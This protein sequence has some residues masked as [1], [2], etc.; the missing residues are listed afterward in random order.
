MKKGM[1]EVQVETDDKNNIRIIQPWMHED[2]AVILITPEQ[3]DTLIQWLQEAK[4]EI[5]NR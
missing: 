4:K 3:V 2:D 5:E 1:M